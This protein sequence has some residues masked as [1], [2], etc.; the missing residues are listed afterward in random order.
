MGMVE[1]LL[2]RR[3]RVVDYYG[4]HDTDVIFLMLVHPAISRYVS[5]PTYAVISI[6]DFLLWLRTRDVDWNALADRL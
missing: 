4:L 2:S 6:A 3:M 1:S 5:S